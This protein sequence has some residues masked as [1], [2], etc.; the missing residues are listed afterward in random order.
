MYE[1]ETAVQSLGIPCPV[2]PDVNQLARR[3]N[4]QDTYDRLFSDVKEALELLPARSQHITHPSKVA[5]YALLARLHLITGEYREALEASS[6]ALRITDVLMDYNELNPS[7]LRSFPI[8]IVTSNPEIL[9]YATGALGTISNLNV[10]VDSSLYSL[11]SSSDLRKKLY[12]TE[13]MNYKGSYS[14]STTPFMGLATDELHLIKAECE[15]RLGEV[16]NALSTL[17]RFRSKRYDKKDFKTITETDE[18]EIIKIVLLE[19]RRE[20]VGRGI[21]WMDL[22]RLNKEPGK[23]RTLIRIIEGKTHTL[24]PGNKRY[25]MK[26]PMDEIVSSGIMQNL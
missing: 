26:I 9:Y 21:T 18:E 22:R 16:E 3:S 24:E 5:A 23:E 11:Y 17:N 7:Q 2:S 15:T 19:R 14:G 1:R 10:Y 13:L 8:P 6:E 4:L 25:L 12:Y 20:L